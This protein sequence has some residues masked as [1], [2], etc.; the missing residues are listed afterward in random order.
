M[1]LGAR[2]LCG[3]MGDR[4]GLIIIILQLYFGSGNTVY[5]EEKYKV[6]TPKTV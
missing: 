4:E 2:I 5:I 1:K 6:L 3:E